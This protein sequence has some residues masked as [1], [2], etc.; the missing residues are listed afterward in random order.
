[1]PFMALG[2]IVSPA[3]QGLMS[4]DISADRQ[5]E[6]QGVLSSVQ[7]LAMII[8]PLIMTSLFRFFTSGSTSIHL[9][10]APFFAAGA[11]ALLAFVMLR[12]FHSQ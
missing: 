5:G 2:V 12:R 3:L 10:G 6:L 8:S 11:L 1:M 4:A 7:G 9:P